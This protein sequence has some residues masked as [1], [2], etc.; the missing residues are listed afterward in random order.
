MIQADGF[1]SWAE[2]DPGPA[3]RWARWG[4]ARTPMTHIT[5]HS[6]EGWFRLLS[7]NGYSPMKDPS[8]WP[9]AWHG[10]VRRS[11]GKLFQHYPVW[12]WLQHGHTGNAYGPGFESEDEG[13]SDFHLPL[14][15]EQQVT[16]LRIY[17]DMEAYTGLKYSRQKRTLIEH[18]EWGANTQCP[19][20]LYAPLW[21]QLEE[22]EMDP[23][24][25]ELLR[26]TADAIAG[27]PTSASDADGDRV[28][29][30][31]AIAEKRAPMYQAIVNQQEALTKH[32]NNHPVGA[33]A[34]LTDEELREELRGLGSRI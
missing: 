24:H 19:S 25:L 2:R 33:P 8:R 12:A 15:L 30:M 28:S 6:L 11:D 13:S 16:F 1:F 18:N 22:P 9:T 31:R 34:M 14:T 23:K 7:G 5:H 21:K 26:L 27:H 32:V 29:K 20:G 3:D 10:T 4:N 17:I